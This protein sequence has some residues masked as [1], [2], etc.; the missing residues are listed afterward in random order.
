[1]TGMELFYFVILPLLIVAAGW[2]AAYLH[3]RSAPNDKI[4]PGE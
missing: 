2:L 1:M 4:H 3:E